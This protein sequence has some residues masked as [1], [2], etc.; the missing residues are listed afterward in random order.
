MAAQGSGR[1]CHQKFSRALDGT[2]DDFIVARESGRRALKALIEQRL[3]GVSA[4][5]Q[6]SRARHAGILQWQRE[7]T[8]MAG[9]C[10]QVR[11]ENNRLELEAGDDGA[12]ALMWRKSWIVWKAHV[13][14]TYNILKK[15]R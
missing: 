1:D 13:K 10:A 3:E 8:V 2:L 15:R 9:R 5:M 12:N 6:R 7:R 14:E 4:E 11:L